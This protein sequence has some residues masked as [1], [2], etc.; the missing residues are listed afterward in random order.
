MTQFSS[1]EAGV[2]LT[3][4]QGAQ[5]TGHRME[6]DTWP[7]QFDATSLHAF[8]PEELQAV[9]K[10]FAL[11]PAMKA[12]M[13][14]DA[15]WKSLVPDHLSCQLAVS[16]QSHLD[17]MEQAMLAAALEASLMGGAASSVGE[18]AD[19]E[20]D[21]NAAIAAS[22][23]E[24]HCPGREDEDYNTA[25]AASLQDKGAASNARGAE[26]RVADDVDEQECIRR[27]RLR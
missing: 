16:E 11:L 6:F 5:H 1:W 7:I 12:R 22:L 20:D 2:I 9:R 13:Q 19:E 10:E 21:Y 25:I 23:Q 8:G 14:G 17:Q 15:N 4:P 26:K 18:G 24:S 3:V 27:A